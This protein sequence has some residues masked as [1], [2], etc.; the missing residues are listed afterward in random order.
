M[1]WWGLR[2]GLSSDKEPPLNRPIELYIFATSTASVNDIGGSNSCSDLARMVFPEPGAPLINIL[3]L[4]AAATTNALFAK[5]WPII[6]K[7]DIFCDFMLFSGNFLT[8]GRGE[9]ESRCDI[10]SIKFLAA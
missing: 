4:P 3:W 6:D 1:L 7:N 5:A 8:I 9:V 10:I 2:K